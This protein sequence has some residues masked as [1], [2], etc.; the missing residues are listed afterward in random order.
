LCSDA[1]QALAFAQET[2]F[3]LVGKPPAGAGAKATARLDSLPELQ[4]FLARSQPRPGR[5]VLLE[6]FVR[7]R[8][9]SFDTVTLHGQHVFH[10]VCAYHPTP[11]EVMEDPRR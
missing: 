5:E 9:F 2:G 3:P 1:G 4:R 7:G 11:L 8:E 6:E 10:N